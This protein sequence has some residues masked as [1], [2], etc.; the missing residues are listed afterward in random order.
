MN[1]PE[2]SKYIDDLLEAALVRKN[3]SNDIDIDTESYEEVRS[4]AM[5]M[6]LSAI[7]PEG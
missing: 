2:Y 1:N 7:S 5:D 3:S 4:I 6:E